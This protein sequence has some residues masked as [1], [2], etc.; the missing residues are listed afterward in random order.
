MF[1]KWHATIHG[2]WFRRRM[3]QCSGTFDLGHV[4]CVVGSF[5]QLITPCNTKRIWSYKGMLLYPRQHPGHL[6]WH[7]IILPMIRSE[8]HAQMVWI[9]LQ[10]HVIWA[11]P[12]LLELQ[13]SWYSGIQGATISDQGIFS[14][15]RASCPYRTRFAQC[16]KMC[17]ATLWHVTLPGLWVIRAM[18]L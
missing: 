4:I 8:E 17:S 3:A 14:G 10:W 2:T 5:D 15:I 16:C 7:V 18:S 1:L 6:Q 9:R 12:C 13:V 11:C